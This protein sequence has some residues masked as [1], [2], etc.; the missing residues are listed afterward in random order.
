MSLSRTTNGRPGVYRMTVTE[1]CAVAHRVEALVKAAVP[2]V[3]RVLVHVE[4]AREGVIIPP[5]GAHP[6]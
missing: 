2:N 1:A 4:P 5:P 6:G 3:R